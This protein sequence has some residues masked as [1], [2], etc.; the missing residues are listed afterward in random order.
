MDAAIAEAKLSEDKPTLI[1][2][3][4]T[5]GKGSPNRQGTAKV[6]GEALGDEEI[7][8][9]RAAIGWPYAPFEV[10]QEVYDTWD[11]RAE[12]ARIEAEWQTMFDGYAAQYPEL[13][14]ELK[15]RLA[16]DL[17]ENWSDTVMDALCAAE[18]AAEHIRRAVAEDA[19]LQFGVRRRGALA[20]EL[21]RGVQHP[22]RTLELDL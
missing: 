3:R 15:R 19:A 8:A 9:T 2:A 10:P 18:E 22:L 5:I 4:T 14:A 16:G 21:H 6:H 11:H 1:I 12:G 7:A 13:A 17:P 20:H